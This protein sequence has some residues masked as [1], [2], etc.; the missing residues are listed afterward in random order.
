MMTCE[1]DK[2]QKFAYWRCDQ[3]NCAADLAGLLGKKTRIVAMNRLALMKTR[4]NKTS[5]LSI[6]EWKCYEVLKSMMQSLM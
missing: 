3:M 2:S 5:C 4:A 6:Y 1:Q